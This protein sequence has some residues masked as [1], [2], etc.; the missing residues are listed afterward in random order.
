MPK[1]QPL[2]PV[3]H[4][5]LVLPQVEGDYVVLFPDLPGAMTRCAT[6][7]EVPNHAATAWLD[8]CVNAVQ[9]GR[10]V[11]APTDVPL[12]LRQRLP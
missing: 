7:E 5:F 4:P 3:T 6:L 9:H 12:A 11:P 1:N 8:W 10:E 2:A